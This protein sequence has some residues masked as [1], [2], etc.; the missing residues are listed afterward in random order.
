MKKT[1]L[2]LLLISFVSK[3]CFATNDFDY[4]INKTTDVNFNDTI[5]I[6][7][8]S[9]QPG[10]FTTFDFVPLFN[11]SIVVPVKKNLSALIRSFC[12]MCSGG[13]DSSTT[14]LE[15]NCGDNS[16]YSLTVTALNDSLTVDSTNGGAIL[17]IPEGEFSAHINN[18]DDTELSC[19]TYLMG[20]GL[21]TTPEEGYNINLTCYDKQEDGQ[22]TNM[23]YWLGPVIGVV[24]AA[25]IGG[26]SYAGVK[27]AN[28]DSILPEV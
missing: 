19:N 12:K 20:I 16:N 27:I 17:G 1:I 8:D 5:T 22:K 11:K 10:N 25:L 7:D 13:Y 21:D 6:E 18:K 26:G 9:A 15:T 4:G 23:W 28:G 24:G 2:T 3:S 14:I